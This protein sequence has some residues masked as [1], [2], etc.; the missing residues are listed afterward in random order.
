MRTAR[1]PTSQTPCHHWRLRRY[2]SQRASAKGLVKNTAVVPVAKL[3]RDFYNWEQRHKQILELIKKKKKAD[4]VFFGDSITHMFGG[5]PKSRISRGRKIWDRYYGHRNAINMGFGW[6]RTQNVLWRLANGELEGVAPKVAVVLIGT[7]NLT[8]TR[9]ARQNSPAEI[10]EGVDA[11]CK[12]I[13][14]KAPKCKIILLS[15][16]PR[17]PARFVKP[18]QEINKLL[19]PLDKEKY[20]TFLNVYAQF[21]D[22]NGLPRKEL[23]ADGVHPNAAGYQVW[24]ET[25]EPVLSKL[26]NDKAVIPDKKEAAAGK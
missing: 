3:E 16:L 13:H 5:I 10:V 12:A 9:N 23:M 25:M 24:A 20:I 8:G 15:V 21:V 7:N 26:L 6:D 17:S 4:L 1:K 11:V 2:V 22:K 19:T 18:I 14:K